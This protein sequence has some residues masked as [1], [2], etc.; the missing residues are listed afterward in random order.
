LADCIDR[1][2]DEVQA[3]QEKIRE[4]VED[5][6]DVAAT[7]DPGE[8]TCADRQEKFAELID[9]FERAED[10]IRLHMATVM[11]SFLAGLFVGEGKFEEIRDNLDL[12]RWFRLP[13]SH[14]R[15]I[16][17][18]RHAG[19]RIVQDGPTLVLALDAHAA[20]PG[21]F[22]A[23]QL[24]PYRTAREPPCQRDALNRRKVMRK[25]DPRRNARFSSP[26]WNVSIAKRPPS[27]SV[28]G[29]C[30]K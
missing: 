21:P 23:E 25:R 2:L 20:H 6:K 10:P 5:I 4:Y 19:V 14:E 8:Q 24:L 15:R 27:S 18:H 30:N 1:G 17:G 11:M 13:K 29:H 26:S 3:E 22:T 7:L 9:R 16:H 28:S 12:E